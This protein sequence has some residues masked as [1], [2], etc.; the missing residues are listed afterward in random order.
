MA[1]AADCEVGD[2]WEDLEDSG[3]LDERLKHIKRAEPIPSSN[4]VKP[5]QIVEEGNRTQYQ[6]TVKILKRRPED[7]TNTTNNRQITPTKTLEQR[8]ADYKEARMRIFG[9][10]P[11]ESLPGYEESPTSQYTDCRKKTSQDKEQSSAN[12]TISEPESD[13]RP[14]RLLQ[15]LDEMRVT[16]NI[17]RQPRGPDGSSGFTSPR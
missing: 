11:P 6:P 1:D 10:A 17:T 4:M 8:Q 15:Q 2:S 5:V 7:S 16:D 3:V 13:A 14:A 9:S 12:N